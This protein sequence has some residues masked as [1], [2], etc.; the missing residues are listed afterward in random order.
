MRKKLQDICKQ[1][2]LGK[3]IEETA[4]FVQHPIDM[5]RRWYGEYQND[6]IFLVSVIMY[7]VKWTE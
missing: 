3:T 6:A 1:F 7:I 5:V 4:K 2:K